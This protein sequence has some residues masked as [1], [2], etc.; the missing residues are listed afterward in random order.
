MDLV[1]MSIVFTPKIPLVFTSN[2]AAPTPPEP[3]K[4]WHKKVIRRFVN[5]R[6]LAVPIEECA[7]LVGHSL[8]ECDL[9]IDEHNLQE[10]INTR[11]HVLIKDVMR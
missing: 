1:P 8:E 2:I 9:V 11:R 4:I 5:L 3:L 6:A 10:A 7:K